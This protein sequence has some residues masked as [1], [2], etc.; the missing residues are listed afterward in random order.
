MAKKREIDRTGRAGKVIAL[1]L[2]V[3]LLLEV[4]FV[5]ALIV[6]GIGDGSLSIT[7]GQRQGETTQTGGYSYEYSGV[8]FILDNG[9]NPLPDVIENVSPSVVGIVTYVESTIRNRDELEAYGSGSGFIVSE[10]GYILTNQHVIDGA[11]EVRVLFED[12]TE[13]V[14]DLIGSDVTTDVA[15]L[16]IEAE[17]LVPLVLGDSDAI[18][19][20]EFVLAIGNP[21]DSSELYGT[22][23]FGIVSATARNVNIDGFSNEYIQ[24]DA[25]VNFGNSGG[26][27]LN[28]S[29]EVIGMNTAKTVTAGYDEYGNAVAAEGIG[30][31]LPINDVVA[32]MEQLKAE[33]KVERPGIG[34]TVYTLSELDAEELGTVAG[35]FIY[36]VTEGGPADLGGIEAGDVIIAS[37]DMIITEQEHLVE[38]IYGAGIGNPLELTVYRNGEEVD[39]TIIV[40][41]MNT[42]P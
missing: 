11:Q 2:V 34:V 27:L 5:G 42:M 6:M 14:A 39:L 4:V 23:T 12:G 16:K 40:G 17:G 37:G 41:D 7:V 9:S 21:L 24:T 36:T 33:G 38:A 1:I 20:G 32:I 13:V 3:L 25:A 10:D 22:V 35:V 26:P 18:R 30:F 29:G 8:P 19:V 15:L 31:A 28:M